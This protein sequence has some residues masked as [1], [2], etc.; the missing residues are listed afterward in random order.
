MVYFS[1]T[2]QDQE[3]KSLIEINTNQIRHILETLDNKS[4]LSF[5]GA[6]FYCFLTNLVL[7]SVGIREEILD[8]KV[9]GSSVAV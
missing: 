3:E 2:S 7:F 4:N 6:I 1:P 9:W 5:V 8:S